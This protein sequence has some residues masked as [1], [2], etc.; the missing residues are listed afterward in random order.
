MM[1][2]ASAFSLILPGLDAAE[3]ML[4]SKVGSAG[5]VVTGMALG[6]ML[7]LG[8]ERFTP[9]AHEVIGVSGPG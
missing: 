3:T 6:V 5:V 9:H 7:M 1:L 2:A 4:G 8:L